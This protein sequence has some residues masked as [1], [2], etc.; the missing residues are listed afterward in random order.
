MKFHLPKKGNL[1]LNYLCIWN[2]FH[3][4]Q[5]KLIFITFVLNEEQMNYKTY[6]D[7]F[8]SCSGL[9]A[10]HSSQQVTQVAASHSATHKAHLL[11]SFSFRINVTFTL[12]SFTI[13]TA[14][15]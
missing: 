3:G 14:A 4:A 10:P 15:R 2:T 9:G 7:V 6:F 8:D 1:R 13:N 11:L 12:Q 5:P